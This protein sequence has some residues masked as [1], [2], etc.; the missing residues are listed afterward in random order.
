MTSIGQYRIAPQGLGLMG[1]TWVPAAERVSDEQAFEVIKTAIDAASPDRLLLNTGTFYGSLADSLYANLQLLRR[2]F[3]KYPELKDKVVVNVKGGVNIPEFQEK[4]WA[5]FRLS[6][7]VED[8]R[9]DLLALRKELGT[10]EGGVPVHVYEM[11]RRDQS[12]PMEQTIKNLNQLRKEGLFEYIALSEVG[13]DSIEKGVKT[14][15]EEGTEIVSVEVEY[16]PFFLD[17]AS[18]GV[19]DTCRSLSVPILV[20]SPIGRGFLGGQLKTRDDLAPNDPRRHQ[21]QFSE[22]NFPKNV[23]VAEAFTQLAKDHSPPVTPAQLAL[24]WAASQSTEGCALISIPGSSKPERVKENM[25]A[26]KI[27]LSEDE[28][29]KLKSTFA[30]LG[31]SGERYAAHA[32]NN[33]SL[34]A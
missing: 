6:A 11:C 24:A 19:L 1:L 16:S 14:A 31:V 2:F 30:S 34:F 25:A 10:D 27:Q 33:G 32:R 28:I 23:K 12:T 5:G 3:T 13:A 20:Y 15:K 29:E 4:G 22:E 18:N 17:I 9:E 26:T 21:D 7:K 8:L